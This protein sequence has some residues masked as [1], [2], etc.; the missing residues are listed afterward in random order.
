M[1]SNPTSSFQTN[2]RTDTPASRLSRA[3]W[4]LFGL[5][6]AILC[7]TE[8]AVRYVVMPKSRIMR[9][10]SQDKAEAQHLGSRDILVVGNSLLNLGLDLPLFKQHMAPEWIGHRFIV[11]STNFSDWY[12]GLKHLFDKGS[13]PYAVGV[14]LTPRQLATRTV[15]GDTFGFHLMGLQDLFQVASQTGMHRTAVASMALANRSAFYGFRGDLRK[16]L[17]FTIYPGLPDLADLFN[18]PAPLLS[19]EEAYQGA[20]PSL[21]EFKELGQRYGTRIVIII[22]PVVT[23]EET[24]PRVVRAGPEAGVAVL[25]PV[26][27]GSIGEEYFGKDRYHLNEKG[28]AVFTPRLASALKEHLAAPLKAQNSH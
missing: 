11:E 17:M 19:P 15:Q 12:F 20:L 5:I 16:L 23:A 9:R 10:I 21:R 22:P 2:V 7:F 18:R 8:I 1:I 24:A 27:S 28:M 13:R 6:A 3:T 4:V 25:V 14:T 26:P